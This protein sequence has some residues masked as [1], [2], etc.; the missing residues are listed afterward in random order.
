VS[1]LATLFGSAIGIGLVVVVLFMVFMV[2]IGYPLI[3]FRALRRL[4]GIQTEFQRLNEALSS[5]VTIT[6]TGPLGL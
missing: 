2:T 5:K 3:A 4:H 6:K 1:N